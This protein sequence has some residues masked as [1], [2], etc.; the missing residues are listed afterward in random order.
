MLQLITD[1]PRKSLPHARQRQTT[2]RLARHRRSRRGHRP[3]TAGEPAPAFGTSR[4]VC[5]QPIWSALVRRFLNLQK[6]VCRSPRLR[7]VYPF[8]R[9]HGAVTASVLR[10]YY[11]ADVTQVVVASGGVIARKKHGFEAKPG[12]RSHWSEQVREKRAW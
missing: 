11:V 7:R 3:A 1:V 5:R 9:L 12:P 2:G 8:R 4:L 10:K 6:G